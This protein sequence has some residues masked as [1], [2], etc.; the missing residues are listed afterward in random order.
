MLGGLTLS[1][2][3]HIQICFLAQLHVPDSL[4]DFPIVQPKMLIYEN[5]RF[6][7]EA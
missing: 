1:Y 6:C 3:E 5:Q 4:H 2:I 7:T